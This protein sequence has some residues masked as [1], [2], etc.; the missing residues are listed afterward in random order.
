MVESQDGRMGWAEDTDH[1]L[2]RT[3]AAES[4]A[5]YNIKRIRRIS[6]RRLYPK[7]HTIP[8]ALML[9]ASNVMA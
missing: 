5:A 1:R 4:V 7:C 8:D 9:I 2:N 3:E 6:Y